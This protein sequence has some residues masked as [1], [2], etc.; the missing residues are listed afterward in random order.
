[1]IA[2]IET[3]ECQAPCDCACSREAECLRDELAQ[4]CRNEESLSR[5]LTFWVPVAIAEAVLLLA[6]AWAWMEG[7]L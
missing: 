5:M 4:S 2:E 6:A 1:M 7:V 3:S